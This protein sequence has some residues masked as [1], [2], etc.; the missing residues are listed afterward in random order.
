[1]QKHLIY[2]RSAKRG[3]G[4]TPALRTLMKSCIR[5]TLKQENVPFLCEIA[6][7][8]TDDEDIREINLENRGIDSATDVLSFPML[9]WYD[10]E[11]DLPGDADL[12][13]ETGA[14]FLGDMVISVERAKQ[15]AEEYGHSFE[16]ECGYLTV[17]SILHLL[18][19]DHVD[20]EERKALMRE[21]EERVMTA[22]SLTR[23]KE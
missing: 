2:I 20:D 15:Q 12:D 17:H 14:V 8:L 1:M 10:G 16:R 3:M 6:V 4:S 21:H 23:D 9:D 7:R 5:E 18:G 11:G 22:L 19:Y 13:P